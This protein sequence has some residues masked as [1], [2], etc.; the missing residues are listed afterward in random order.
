V[1]S[2]FLD[3]AVNSNSTNNFGLWVALPSGGNM[4]PLP[5]FTQSVRDAVKSYQE[6]NIYPNPARAGRLNIAMSMEDPIVD[7]RVVDA[8]GRL[9]TNTTLKGSGLQTET[10]DVSSFNPGLYFVHMVS[11]NH[12]HTKKVFV[13]R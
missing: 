5:L 12:Q 10:L 6:V 2:G 8:T 11:E 4:I 3:P 13:G 1:A 7:I 9:I